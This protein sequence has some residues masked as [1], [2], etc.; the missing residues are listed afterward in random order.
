M[1]RNELNSMDEG[2][3]TVIV[4]RMRSSAIRV[5]WS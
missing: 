3:L 1:D 2:V 4:E 5:R